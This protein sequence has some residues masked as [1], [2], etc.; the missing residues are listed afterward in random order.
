[1]HPAVASLLRINRSCPLGTTDTSAKAAPVVPV[2]SFRP[3]FVARV[4]V[5]AAIVV[6]ASRWPTRRRPGSADDRAARPRRAPAL[7][8]QPTRLA[9][10]L[11][12]GLSAAVVRLLNNLTG[13]QLDHLAADGTS[14]LDECGRVFV[15][16]HAVAPAQQV[17]RRP[18]AAR[19]GPGR[20]LR[21]LVASGAPRARSTSTST[22]P[23]TPAPGGRTAPRSCR[24]PTRIDADRATFTDVERAQIYLAWR[25]V[26]EDYAPFDVNVTTLRPDPSALSRTT[27]SRPDLRHA[28]RDQPHQLRRLGLRLRRPLLRRHLRH[29]RRHRLPAGVDL[30]QRLRHRRLQRGPDHQPRGRPHLRPEPRRH[31]PGVRTT[32]APRAGARSWAPPTTAR[33]SHWSSGEYADA[34]NTEDDTAIIARTAPVVADDHAGTVLGATRLTAG[35]PVAGTITT[36]TDT[37]AFT[38]SAYSRTALTVAG[39]AGVL[40]PRRPAHDPQPARAPRSPPSTRPPTSPTTRRWPPRG[41]ST[42]PPPPRRYTA[43]VDGTGF[44][45]PSEAGRYS[46][47]GSL[48]AYAVSLATGGSTAHPLTTSTSPD[49]HHLDRPHVRR[50]RSPS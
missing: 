12:S 43:V 41:R 39:P 26:A 6:A 14:W 15:A 47:Y 45:A 36:R 30:H 2:R 10:A 25:T 21:A 27:S 49:G 42:C 18:R 44:G 7:L 11:E 29:R 16:D 34:N 35:T 5:V 31:Q 38:F 13:D 20:R 4:L 1:M 37:D 40:Q 17:D 33:A 3:S 28:R 24:R 23:P 50:R 46:D 48:G 22:A 9:T 8:Q 32:P 19:G